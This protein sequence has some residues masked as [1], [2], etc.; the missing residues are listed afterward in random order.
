MKKIK[1]AINGFGRIGR[2]AFKLLLPHPEIEIVA[3]NDLTDNETLIHLLKYDST[4][5]RLD[6]AI[7]CDDDFIYVDGRKIDAIAIKNPEEL[8]W[9]Q[10]EVDIVLECTGRFRT[11]EDASKHLKAGA[12]KVIISAPA[13][14]DIKTIVLGVNEGIL[15]AEDV[16]ISNASC[17]TNCLA[18]MIKVL[19][20][21]FGLEK[22]FVTTIHAYTAD[23]N[24]QDAPHKEDLRRARAA[25]MNIVPTTT[26]AGTALAKVYPSSAGKVKAS[27][28]RVPV[29]DGSLT[30]IT[31]ILKKEVTKEQINEAFKLASETYLKDIVEFTKEPLVST[32]IIG[33]K[34]SAIFDS[35]L[36]EANGNFIKVTGWYDNEYG[37]SSRLVNM[38]EYLN[39]N[40]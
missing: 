34:H 20:E 3:V 33:N 36:T 37:Y 7:S 6:V 23:Q 10:Y 14:G 26:N 16:I 35:L 31:A 9:K 40:F 17:T 13:K 27:A 39:K 25:A 1:V 22:A 2:L 4:H 29:I 30:E 8:P 21:N 12:K 24:L 38:I 32:D 18:P 19:E 28:V 11:I 15:S 5:G